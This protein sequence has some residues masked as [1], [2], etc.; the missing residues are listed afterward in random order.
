MEVIHRLF[1]KV[2]TLIKLKKRIPK[3]PKIS[4]IEVLCITFSPALPFAGLQRFGRL[5]YMP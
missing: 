2:D 4:I 5:A 3:T 1:N